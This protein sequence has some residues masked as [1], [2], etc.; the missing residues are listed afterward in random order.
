[1][2]L[3]GDLNAIPKLF[4]DAV[5]Q[6]GKLV[7]NEAQLARVELSQKITQLGVGAAY[8]AAAAIVCIPALVVLLIALALGL[9]QLGLSPVVAHVASAVCGGAISIILAMAG[10]RHLKPENLKPKVTMQQV[11]RD[12]ATAKELAR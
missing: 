2:S 6:L 3:S 5:E 12:V 10:M 11:E 8:L 1:M 9:T 7:Q 4:G